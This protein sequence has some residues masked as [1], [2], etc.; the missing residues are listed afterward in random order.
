MSARILI[1]DD[2]VPN[3][4][5]LEVK[6][7]AQ[8]YDV[9]TAMSGKQALKLANSEKFDLILLDAM[10]PGMNG[11]EVCERLKNNPAT[12]HIPVVMVTALEETKDRIRGLKAGADTR[13]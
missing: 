12:W 10:M 7:T 8:Y 1:V 9:V 4:N 13:E 6:L 3:L 2:L 5:L 11:F